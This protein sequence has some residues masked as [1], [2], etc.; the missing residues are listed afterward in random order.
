M[1]EES[2]ERKP[3]TTSAG[4][5]KENKPDDSRKDAGDPVYADGT[6]CNIDGADGHEGV[7]DDLRRSSGRIVT[8]I[9][10]VQESRTEVT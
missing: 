7:F 3:V 6:K 9:S 10:R 2:G 8:D 1:I 5:G 4:K